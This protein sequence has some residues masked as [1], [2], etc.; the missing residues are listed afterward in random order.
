MTSFVP[1][2]ERHGMSSVILLAHL[3]G[4]GWLRRDGAP[5]GVPTFRY[6]LEAS[7][8]LTVEEMRAGVREALASGRL[9]KVRT[10]L[11]RFGYVSGAAWRHWPAGDHQVLLDD[12]NWN[13]PRRAIVHKETA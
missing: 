1:R 7:R 12:P 13:S 9:V 11:G 2:G 3:D 10:S 4:Y 8:V 6:L 5:P